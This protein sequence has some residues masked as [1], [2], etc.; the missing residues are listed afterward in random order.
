MEP[1]IHPT[2]RLR[3]I[4]TRNNL[5]VSDE[6]LRLLEAYAES[7]LAA[8]KSINLISRRDEENFWDR[9]I[10]HSLSILILLRFRDGAKVLDLGSGGGLPGIPLKIL[11]PSMRLTMVDSTKKKISAVQQI[12]AQLALKDTDAI[13]SR[14]EDLAQDVKFKEQFDIVIARAVASLQDLARLASPLLKKGKGKEL[15][16]ERPPLPMLLDEPSLVVYKGGDIEAELEK[17]K[18]IRY[19]RSVSVRRIIVDG[20][21]NATL[22]DKKVVIIQFN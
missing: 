5:L 15:G 18:R 11:C 6:A 13:W 12:V 22:E 17:T 3:Q 9:H 7:L 14:A 1:T 2:L 20:F 10:L 21:E 16:G 4:L 19:V 8:N